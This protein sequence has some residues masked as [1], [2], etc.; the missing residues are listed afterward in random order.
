VCVL[1]LVLQRGGA[2]RVCGD[3]MMRTYVIVDMCYLVFFILGTHF[4]Q[5]LKHDIS[6]T[7]LA[8]PNRVRSHLFS[9]LVCIFHSCVK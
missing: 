6:V 2:F 4:S 1:H 8:N 3:L 5:D 7:R 9:G